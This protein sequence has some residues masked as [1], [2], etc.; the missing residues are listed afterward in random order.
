MS[1]C[2]LQFFAGSLVLYFYLCSSTA[3]VRAGAGTVTFHLTKPVL[4]TKERFGAL[5]E[6]KSD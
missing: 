1:P 3:S 6:Q 4:D 2:F 5:K